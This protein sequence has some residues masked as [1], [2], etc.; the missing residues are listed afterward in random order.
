MPRSSKSALTWRWEGMTR[1]WQPCQA[2]ASE[3]RAAS[4][5]LAWLGVAAG[6]LAPA[7]PTTRRHRWC[8]EPAFPCSEGSSFHTKGA[9]EGVDQRERRFVGTRPDTLPSSLHAAQSRSSKLM[10]LQAAEPRKNTRPWNEGKQRSTDDFCGPSG[11][12][13]REEPARVNLI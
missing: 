12:H 5:L 4:R 11:R 10:C 3:F 8:L 9:H 6:R 13:A 7:C 2:A 1:R